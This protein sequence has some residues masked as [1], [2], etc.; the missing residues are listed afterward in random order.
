[1]E[2]GHGNRFHSKRRH[3][4]ATAVAMAIVPIATVPIATV[5]IAIAEI[6]SF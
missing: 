3:R 2:G 1:M 6:K 5:S 4:I